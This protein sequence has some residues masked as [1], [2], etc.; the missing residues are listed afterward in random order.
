LFILENFLV[1][2]IICYISYSGW[3]DPLIIPASEGYVDVVK[4]LIEERNASIS[5]T[6]DVRII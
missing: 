6:D 5:D 1:S 4:Y 3:S 2:R